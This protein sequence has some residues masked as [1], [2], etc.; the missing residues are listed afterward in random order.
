MK[1]MLP[2]SPTAIQQKSADYA[3]HPTLFLSGPASS[4]KTSA[5]LL[6]LQNILNSSTNAPVLVLVPQRSLAVPYHNN[7]QAMK[8][9]EGDRV[10]IQTMSSMVRRMINLFWPVIASYQIFKQPFEA[11]R[12]LTLETS[13]YYMAQI[14]RPMIDQ[15]RFSNVTLPPFRLYSQIIDNLNKSALV[16]FPSTEIGQR[17]SS[18]FIGDSSRQNVFND[19][20]DAVNQFRAYCLAHNLVD[21]SLQVGLFCHTLWPNQTFQKYLSN[22]YAHLIYDNAEED[23]P[24]VHDIIAQWLPNLQSA[25]IIYDDQAGYRSFLGADPRSALL[26]EK[27]CQDSLVTTQN[28]VSSETLQELRSCFRDLKGCGPSQDLI[29]QT[30]GFPN[31]RMRFFPELLNEL[32]KEIEEIRA[33]PGGED[34]K[35]A[36]LA[37]Y[38][39]D[40]LRFSLTHNLEDLGLIVSVQKPSS[41]LMQDPVIKT[42][43]LLSKF[44][45][46][47]WQIRVSFLD[48]AVALTNSIAGL[49]LNRAHLLLGGFDP[50]N[51]YLNKLP[52]P[53]ISDRIS[54]ELLER[55]EALS[56]WLV[57]TDPDEP[58]D[59]YLSRL[60]GEVLSQPGFHFENNVQAGTSTAVLMESFHKFSLSLD[61]KMQSD[62]K[63]ASHAFIEAIDSGLISAF[64]LSDWDGQAEDDVLIAP[65]LSFLMRNQPVDYQFWLNIGSKGW[66]ERLEQPLT[67]PIVLSRNWEEGKQWTADDETAYNQA[68]LQRTIS[69]LLLRC[70]EKVF[71][72]TSDYNEAGVEER[73][74]LLTIFQNL[75]RKAIRSNNER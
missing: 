7:L 21:Y 31:K 25:L 24:Y 65:V 67:H 70:R 22:Q 26:L 5:A 57:S 53:V 50:V 47:G 13:Q 73:G 62:Q 72:L 52:D 35:I 6:R 59:S 17:L 45:Y 9:A 63:M 33:L 71:A 39:S 29:R 32:T 42:L 46:P 37:P 61:Q 58:L 14:V 34:K 51:P 68:N 75:F 1:G 23:P 48:A 54:T 36:I 16:G 55:Y 27:S 69:G 11:P 20:Q 41:S 40:S 49:D 44:A 4:G 15:G 8:I 10:S 64:Y 30:I 74:Q 19:V 3:G 12:F 56:S 38:I 28:F 18:A 43:I 60:F 2:Q 66:Y